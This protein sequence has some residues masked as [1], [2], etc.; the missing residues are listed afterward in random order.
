MTRSRGLDSSFGSNQ[1]HRARVC[2]AYERYE[3]YQLRGTSIC[4]PLVAKGWK[5][6]ISERNLMQLSQKRVDFEDLTTCLDSTEGIELAYAMDM[7]GTRRINPEAHRFV[8]SRRQNVQKNTFLTTIFTLSR[9]RPLNSVFVL[10]SDHKDALEHSVDSWWYSRHKNL[11]QL[12]I[13]NP[14]S[15][16]I[17]T[18]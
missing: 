18:E 4:G 16:F 11:R 1:G 6:S 5:R 12:S 10:I 9:F 13:L 7:N 2:D 15:A 3:A 14:V 8:D 17:L